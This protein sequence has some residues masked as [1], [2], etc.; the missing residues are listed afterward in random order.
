MKMGSKSLW[1]Q[2]DFFENFSEKR[3]SIVVSWNYDYL[4]DSFDRA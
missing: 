4:E 3:A 1:L 2:D